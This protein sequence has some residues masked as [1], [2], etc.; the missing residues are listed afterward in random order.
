MSDLLSN[1]W[2]DIDEK[3]RNESVHIIRNSLDEMD[4]TLRDVIDWARRKQEGE[5]NGSS[6]MQSAE[7]VAEEATFLANAAR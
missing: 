6:I 4:R 5:A 7:I 2:K 1:K 3:E